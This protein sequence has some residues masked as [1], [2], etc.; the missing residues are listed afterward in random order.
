MSRQLNYKVE[1][2]PRRGIPPWL[3]TTDLL[4]ADDI[5]CLVPVSVVFNGLWIFF[6]IVLLNMKSFSILTRQS[7]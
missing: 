4:Y 5:V 3:E 1:I 2:P 7:E 6:V